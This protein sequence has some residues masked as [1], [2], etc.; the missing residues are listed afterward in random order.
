MSDI[1][2]H[3][4]HDVTAI[5]SD[6]QRN[7]DFYTRVLGCGR[8]SRPSTSTPRTPTTSTALIDA[9]SHATSLVLGSR[10]YGRVI[11]ALPG[12]V[13]FAVAA[14][15]RCLV[16]VVKDEAVDQ[17]VGPLHRVVDRLAEA[18]ADRARETHPELTVTT[19]VDDCPAEL[20]L[21]SASSDAGMVV[22]A[23]VGEGQG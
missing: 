22:V 19:R 6:P 20:T 16:I 13:T 3:G 2:P 9:S 17:P 4:L 1:R 5:A 23:A 10:R 18:A 12:S 21:T 14:R 11:G 15:A 8:S 7:V